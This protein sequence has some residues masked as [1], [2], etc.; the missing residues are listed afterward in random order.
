MFTIV[1]RTKHCSEN[2]LGEWDAYE[3]TDVYGPFPSFESAN[4]TLNKLSMDVRA[5]SEVCEVEPPPE[6]E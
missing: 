2:R 4:K 3:T 6:G 5:L 1:V